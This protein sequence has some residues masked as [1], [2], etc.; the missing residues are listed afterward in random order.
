MIPVHGWWYIDIRPLQQTHHMREVRTC[1]PNAGLQCYSLR[2]YV[3]RRK[4]SPEWTP[5]SRSISNANILIT[6]HSCHTRCKMM[7]TSDQQSPNALQRPQQRAQSSSLDNKRWHRYRHTC[8]HPACGISNFPKSLPPGR[9][10]PEGWRLFWPYLAVNLLRVARARENRRSMASQHDARASPIALAEPPPSSTHTE[11]TA[12]E[13]GAGFWKNRSLACAFLVE[14]NLWA[15]FGIGNTFFRS[16]TSI[17][18]HYL[19]LRIACVQ[20]VDRKSN[21]SRLSQ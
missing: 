3:G 8:R 17:V 5:Q 19:S 21:V 1:L 12:H 7:D 14:P 2:Y 10:R 9:D 11:R 6:E 15:V 4:T 13:P 18:L 20:T 16:E